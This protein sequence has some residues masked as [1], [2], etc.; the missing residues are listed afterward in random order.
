M[1]VLLLLKRATRTAVMF[2]GIV[3]FSAHTRRM[4]PVVMEEYHV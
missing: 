2:P 3:S 4:V 1:T